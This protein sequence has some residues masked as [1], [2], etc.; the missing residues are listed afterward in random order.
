MKL[1]L[2]LA[3]LAAALWWLGPRRRPGDRALTQARAVLGVSLRADATEI[4]AA[5]RRLIAAAHPDRGGS[6]ELFRRVNDARD[7]LLRDK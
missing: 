5:H 2:V 6:A 4:R 7:L 1:L 3:L